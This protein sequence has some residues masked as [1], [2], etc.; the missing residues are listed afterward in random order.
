MPDAHQTYKPTIVPVLSYEDIMLRSPRFAAVNIILYQKNGE[1]CFPLIVRKRY[2]HDKHSGEVALPGGQKEHFESSFAETAL[3]ESHEEVG[4][5]RQDIRIIRE[6]SPVYV[7]PS[8]FYVY[9]FI[10][11]TKRNPTFYLQK[12]EVA[13][14]IECPVSRFLSLSEQPEMMALPTTGGIEVPVMNLSGHVIWGATSMIL[15]EFR[16]MLQRM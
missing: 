15:S 8:N 9:P 16:Q 5:D 13:D 14:Y 12:S 1:W 10:S 4:I 2:K 11:Y 3:R 6:M 7:P